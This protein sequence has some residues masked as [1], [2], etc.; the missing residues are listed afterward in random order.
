MARLARTIADGFGVHLFASDAALGQIEFAYAG[1]DTRYQIPVLCVSRPSVVA[2][3]NATAG[4]SAPV[5]VTVVA[6]GSKTAW[7]NILES[8]SWWFFST[9]LAVSS[10]ALAAFAFV[11]LR[12]HYLYFGEIRPGAPQI[13]LLMEFLGAFCSYSRSQTV[14]NF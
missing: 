14:A 1:W 12:E 7:R 8:P 3:V 5:L 2:I 9:F 6:D 13:V 4:A 10:C 11:R